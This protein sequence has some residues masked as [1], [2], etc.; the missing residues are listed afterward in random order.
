MFIIGLARPERNTAAAHLHELVQATYADRY[1]YLHLK[2]LSPADS[3]QLFA[4]LLTIENLPSSTRALIVR[5][6]EGNP[7]FVEEVIRMLIETGL[8]EYESPAGHWR[9]TAQLSQ[10]AIPDTVQGIIMARVDRLDEGVKRVLRLASV[11]GR[12]FFYRVLRALDEADHQMDQHLTE[13]QAVELI[14]EKQSEPELAY[15][16]KHALAQEA[17]YESILLQKRRELHAHVGRVLE[18]MFADRLEE[19]YGLLAYHY[20]RAEAWEK[21]QEYLFKAGDQAVHIAADTEALAYYQEAMA[22][23][24]RVF[25]ERW[26]PLQRASLARK[27]GEA[28]Y[29]RGEHEQALEYFQ[30]AFSSLGLQLPLERWEV[31]RA[32][33]KELAVHITHRLFPRACI[34]PI[35][36]NITAEAEEEGRIY[37]VLAWLALFGRH[38]L[39]IWN[40]LRQLNFAERNG[41]AVGMVSGYGGL[42]AIL[43]TLSQF[44][45]AEYYRLQAT[46]LALQIGEPFVL[47]AD[48]LK[49]A[50]HGL[51][52]SQFDAALIS[53]T[54]AIAFFNETGD[55][56]G[57]G[58]SMSCATTLHLLKGEFP[59]ALRY[60]KS[61]LRLGKGAADSQ[62]WCRGDLVVGWTLLRLGRLDEAA[63][64]LRQARERADAVPDHQMRAAARMLLARYFLAKGQPHTAAELIEDAQT[65]VAHHNIV[66]FVAVAM[67]R[68][69]LALCYLELFEHWERQE[70]HEGEVGTPM[71]KRVW[72]NRARHA[73]ARA[74][75]HG[76]KF[77]AALPEALRLQGLFLWLC[78]RQ[79]K[80]QQWW[81]QSLAQAE[82]LGMQHEVGLT[83]LEIG[84]RLKDQAQL[85]Q[86]E[87]RFA[88]LD[89][90]YDRRRARE[91]LA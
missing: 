54:Q 42:M 46:T 57:Q 32:I 36:D 11:I 23:Y 74:L 43:D 70:P 68:S 27:L 81:Q 7:F 64:N 29:Q 60:A 88:E 63:E 16:F 59:A 40:A 5:K 61:I 55:L 44:Q 50:L 6:A 31:R 20:A 21:A 52:Q 10:L 58:M 34:K 89:A 8:I 83:R 80:A 38:E 1:T 37:A 67:L 15:I 53:A 77:A 76:R 90:A 26:S 75:R 84:V 35:A 19:W 18:V 85:S 45:L 91:A 66:E 79:G 3:G 72:R 51:Y 30:Q 56:H 65:I 4:N 69:T 12:S 28:F 17:T 22:A 82:S 14:Y 2:P 9:A 86:A 49:S 47:G 78:G 13:L 71:S 48:S 39:W 87:A 25:G 24:A 41:Y 62:L 73:C 33:I